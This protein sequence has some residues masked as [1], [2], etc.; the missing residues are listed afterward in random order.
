MAII[1]MK[2]LRE[3]SEKDIADRMRELQLELSKERASSEVGGTVKSPGRIREIRRTIA[4]IRTYATEKEKK[5][6]VMKKKAVKK[7]EQKTD[8]QKKD[9][10]SD[11]QKRGD[12]V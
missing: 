7:A 4:R 10:K 1:K 11:V 2:K 9:Q 6:P 8:I 5:I 3:M 12:R